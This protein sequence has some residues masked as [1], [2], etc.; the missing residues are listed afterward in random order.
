MG[1]NAFLL[2]IRITK[3]AVGIQTSSVGVPRV[4]RGVAFS[5]NAL[6]VRVPANRV[7]QGVFQYPG[8]TH[9][10]G[11][12]VA[13]V[14]NRERR[15]DH[16][17]VD[18]RDESVQPIKGAIGPERAVVIGEGDERPLVERN[19]ELIREFARQCWIE[20]ESPRELDL[21]IIAFSVHRDGAQQHGGGEV[22][23]TIR[24]RHETDSEIDGVNSASRGEF[25]RFVVDARGSMTRSVE[26]D[27]I[28]NKVAKECR[29]AREEP[30]EPA[31]VPGAQFDGNVPREMQKGV[32]FPELSEFVAPLFPH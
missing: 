32:R 19:S 20:V 31:G 24:P 26:R 28:T 18:V 3:Q 17:A 14:R 12:D 30:R 4:D 13:E 11:C 29:G 22:L 8:S 7:Q 6:G 23:V 10:L 25:D 27:V 16:R 5:E 2:G 1:N 15:N 9:H 21:E